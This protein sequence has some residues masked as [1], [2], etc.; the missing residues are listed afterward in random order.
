M[1]LDPV[2]ISYRREDTQGQAR[3]LFQDLVAKLG[4]DGV[5]MDVD[6]IALGKD[7]REVL[8]ERLASCG[9]MLV[10]I[11][12]DWLEGKDKSGRR[13]IDSPTDF[14]SLEIAGAL[15]RNIPITPV[16]LQGAQ[17]PGAEQLPAALAALAYR[18]GFELSHNRWDSDVNELIRRLGLVGPDGAPAVARSKPAVPRWA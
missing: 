12:P 18:N 8:Q 5:F 3:A 2:F 14:V 4:R 13:R 16:L 15:K 9:Q 17:M 10:L 6:S 1:A 11:G 7:F